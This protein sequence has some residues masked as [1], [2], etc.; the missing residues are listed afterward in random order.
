[1]LPKFVDAFPAHS[2]LLFNKK[3]RNRNYTK[4]TYKMKTFFEC[5]VLRDYRAEE[6]L[7]A[8][9]AFYRQTNKQPLL[10]HLNLGRHNHQGKVNCSDLKLGLVAIELLQ[11]ALNCRNYHVC[12][13]KRSTV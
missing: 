1:M 5:R 11:N 13:L 10:I 12:R 6:T 4:I 7:F 2:C 8:D 3:I 9:C